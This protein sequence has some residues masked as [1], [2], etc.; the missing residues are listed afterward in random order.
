[1]KA[2]FLGDEIW[3]ILE[4]I[5]DIIKWVND[6][7]AGREIMSDKI[8]E[9]KPERLRDISWE[10]AV[11]GGFNL[12][13]GDYIYPLSHYTSPEGYMGIV[14][15]DGIHLWFTQYDCVNDASEGVYILEV[16]KQ[17]CND[18]LHQNKISE[19]FHKAIID[20][21][22]DNKEVFAYDSGDSIRGFKSKDTQY[23]ICC[24]SE[25][26]DS[27]AMWN[28]YLKNATY[29]GY[30][31][32]F[33]WDIL[34]Q[35]SNFDSKKNYKLN[36]VKVLYEYKSQFEVLERYV[37]RCYQSSNEENGVEQTR[38]IL[39]T[40]LNQCKLVF[41]NPCFAH[42]K[43]I[44]TILTVAQDKT[45]DFIKKTVL[46]RTGR[47]YI[48]PYIDFT[49][50]EKE[51]LRYVTVAPLKDQELAESTVKSFLNSRG[52]TQTNVTSSK[53]PIRF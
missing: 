8:D 50:T 23:Y 18:L 9:N 35:V 4:Y 42:E 20:I 53:V 17:V 44:R 39:E 38:H 33:D 7:Q 48:I 13:T 16:Y 28:Y 36:F 6:L 31:L 51:L 41:K 30:S 47:G 40:L 5:G 43:E 21:R 45:D 12:Y 26:N 29:H 52:Y 10:V 46:Y 15:D 49:F 25:E 34:S 1:M 19:E 27:L 2:G 37:T 22:P 11:F 32:E 24:F 3:L 14:G